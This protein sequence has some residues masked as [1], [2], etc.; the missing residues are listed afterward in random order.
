MSD[1]A[2]SNELLAAAKDAAA[3][4]VDYYTLLGLDPPS[5]TAEDAETTFQ[6]PTLTREVVQRAW[7]KR[8]LKYHPDKAGAAFD[9][10]KWEEFGLARDI[11]ASEEA[12][13]VYDGARVGLQRKQRERDLMN[14][15]QR[16]FAEELE[17]AEGKSARD[18][19]ARKE[20]DA[21]REKERGQQ[22]AAGR[23]FM[24]ERR[25]KMAEAEERERERERR[26]DDERD[27]KI[28]E[29]EGRIAEKARRRAERK[30]RREGGAGSKSREV[31]GDIAMDVDK[32]SVPAPPALAPDV[33]QQTKI[34]SL[35]VEMPISDDPVKF[36]E[37]QWP[38]TKARLLAAQRAKEVRARKTSTVA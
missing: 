4:N 32:E 23:M 1:A 38:K 34:P 7:R 33:Q 24:E 8:S 37:A 5:T 35:P 12:R 19:E 20:E 6:Q 36:W 21:E 17:K 10:D 11:L 31:D 2:A 9:K 15:K 14:A 22:A 27:A 28:R 16:R 30:A 3:R 26:E 25:K 29:L 13:R 18:A